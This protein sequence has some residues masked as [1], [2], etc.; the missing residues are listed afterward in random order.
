M[1]YFVRHGVTDWNENITPDGRHSA[2]CQGRAD[3]PLN[4]NGIAQAIELSKTLKDIKFDKV[5]CSPLTRT[6]QTCELILGSLDDV[7]FDDRIIERDFGE[8]E[9]LT[10]EEFDFYGFCN[11]NSGMKFEKAETVESIENRVFSFLDELKQEPNQNILIVA[12]GGVGCMFISYFDGIGEDGNYNKNF[13]V[14]HSKPIIR[15]FKDIKHSQ[16]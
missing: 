3:I 2:K 1:I 16:L 8:F 15:D 14:P 5:F 9:G 4:Q 11:K 12:H 13:Y 10:K 7:V 6:K